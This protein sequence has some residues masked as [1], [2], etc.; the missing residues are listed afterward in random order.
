MAFFSDD[1]MTPSHSTFHATQNFLIVV[2]NNTMSMENN[3]TDTN[4]QQ[5][6]TVNTKILICIQIFGCVDIFLICSYLAMCLYDRQHL[7]VEMES[8]Y[9]NVPG[10]NSLYENAEIFLI[11]ATGNQL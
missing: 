11:S 5:Q 4:K 2:E 1:E 3:N 6:R 9:T 10:N 7:T 8:T